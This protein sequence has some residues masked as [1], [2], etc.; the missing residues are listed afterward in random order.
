VSD[1]PYSGTASATPFA[2][3]VN[4]KDKASNPFR[5][6][7]DSWVSVIIPVGPG[8][9][10]LAYRALDSLQA[11]SVLNWDVV[12]VNDSG[13]DLMH[14]PT[15]KPLGHVYPYIIEVN[16]GR[17]G[18]AAARNMGVDNCNSDMLVFLDADDWLL[19]GFMSHVIHAY[20]ENPDRYIYTDWLGLDDK[21]KTSPH[22]SKEFSIKGILAEAL[23]PITTLVPK[24]W[25]V[26]IGGFDTT[27]SGWEDWIYYLD[28]VKAG[29]CG[30]RLGIQGMVYDYTSG[31]RR[32]DSLKKINKLL[33]LVRKRYKEKEMA[34]SSCGKRGSGARSSSGTVPI[35]QSRSAGGVPAMATKEEVSTSKMVA[36]RENSGNIGAHGVVG[37]RTRIN[38]GRHKHGDMFE[39]HID[40]AVSQ[41]QRYV[42][43]ADSRL[44]T[45]VPERPIAPQSA[46]VVAPPA[47]HIKPEVVKKALEPIPDNEVEVDIT[48]LPLVQ[49][50]RLELSSEDAGYAL[51]QEKASDKPRQS[52]INY[53][54][55]VVAGK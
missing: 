6:Y 41:P 13:A 10:N 45:P 19:P 4:V 43:M 35:Q 18:V 15:G 46:E 30:L 9:E 50:K 17:S 40:D 33:P 31:L 38:Y 39:M 25:H 14:P 23:H 44:D 34:C 16:S 5:D 22:L 29:H 11:Q 53:L 36:V 37:V 7:D 47:E 21:K 52:V 8:H 20:N 28:L 12:V 51:E 42:R 49:I 26:E 48:L 2:A 24:A 27:V 1:K 32:E 3:P 55:T 54:E